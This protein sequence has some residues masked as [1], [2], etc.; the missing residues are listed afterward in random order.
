M[1][2]TLKLETENAE[3]TINFDV[4]SSKPYKEMTEM[5][6][7]EEKVWIRFIDSLKNGYDDDIV[8]YDETLGGDYAITCKNNNIILDR[9][10][11]KLKFFISYN[12]QKNLIEFATKIKQLY[13][14]LA[15]E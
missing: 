12:N 10:S 9:D 2:I 5:F 8:L 11:V 14:D 1:I 7:E 4:T 13:H 6:I 15:M 3:C